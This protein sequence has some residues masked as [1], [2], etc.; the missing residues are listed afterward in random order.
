[1]SEPMDDG[2]KERKKEARVKLTRE[3][4]ESLRELGSQW[5][6]MRQ[7]G[8]PRNPK[9]KKEYSKSAGESQGIPNQ[10]KGKMPSREIGNQHQQKELQKKCRI[11]KLK[12]QNKK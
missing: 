3:G 10:A 9:W 6:K 11:P 5:E 12:L 7:V 8:T 2:L 1:M 4:V